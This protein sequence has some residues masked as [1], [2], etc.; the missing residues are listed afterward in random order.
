ML[1]TAP[2][3]VRCHTLGARNSARAAMYTFSTEPR[4]AGERYYPYEAAI[5]HNLV[6][7]TDGEHG[8]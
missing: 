1:S 6:R 2:R 8:E 7:S 4:Q 3:L 5:R